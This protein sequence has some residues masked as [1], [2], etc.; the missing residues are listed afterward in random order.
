MA[1]V[2]MIKKE[3]MINRKGVLEIFTVIYYLRFFWIYTFKVPI[4]LGFGYEKT[5]KRHAEV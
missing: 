5:R 1:S 4:K 3:D 2:G